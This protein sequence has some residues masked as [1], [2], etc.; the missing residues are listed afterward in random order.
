MAWNVEKCQENQTDRLTLSKK[1]GPKD[2]R[3]EHIRMTMYNGKDY[4]NFNKNKKIN[5][6]SYKS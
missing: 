6:F 2:Q 4:V 1:N 5:I 3:P